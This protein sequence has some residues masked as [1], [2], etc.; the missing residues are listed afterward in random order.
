MLPFDLLWLEYCHLI[1]VGLNVSIWFMLIL[2]KLLIARYFSLF[3]VIFHRERSCTSSINVAAHCLIFPL[4]FNV[5]FFTKNRV[6][7]PLLVQLLITWHFLLISMTFSPRIGV[8]IFCLMQLLITRHFLLISIS[9][10]SRMGCASSIN[11]TGHY[12]TFPLDCNV[13]FIKSGVGHSLLLQLL[14]GWYI[15]LVLL[16]IGHR[17]WSNNR[18]THDV[19]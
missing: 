5:I 12:L 10:S 17:S 8:C 14:I 11:A 3:H 19:E 13:I 16:G 4:P 9:F 1:C 2:A 15:L 18:I 7:H 6:V